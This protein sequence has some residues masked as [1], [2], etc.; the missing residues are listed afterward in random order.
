MTQY[1]SINSTL[2]CSDQRKF[3]RELTDKYNKDIGLLHRS[4]GDVNKKAS[5]ANEQMRQA[6]KLMIDVQKKL[7]KFSAL[8]DATERA[9]SNIRTELDDIRRDLNRLAKDGTIVWVLEIA[10][11]VYS[12]VDLKQCTK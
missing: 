3:E 6:G 11:G 2:H 9:E 12:L 1:Y 5:D 7:N 4:M 10:F 8:F